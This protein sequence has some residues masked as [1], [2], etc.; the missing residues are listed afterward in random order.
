LDAENKIIY[1]RKANVGSDD[2]AQVAVVSGGGSGH[3]PSFASYVGDGLL[4]A[5]VAGSIFASPSTSQVRKAVTERVHGEAK[6]VL[7]IIMNYTVTFTSSGF[8]LEC[9]VETCS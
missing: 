5:A 1:R 6:G 3:E 9:R 8:W 7:V 4:S 2:N